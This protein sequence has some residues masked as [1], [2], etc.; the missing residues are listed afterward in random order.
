[1]D[2]DNKFGEI[3]L[4]EDRQE[5]HSPHYLSYEARP[6]VN[7]EDHQENVE[8]SRSIFLILDMESK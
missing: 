6:T 5:G 3:P 1:M 8:N 2:V 7:K 4:K